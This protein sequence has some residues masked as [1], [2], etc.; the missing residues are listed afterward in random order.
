MDCQPFD[1]ISITKH[2]QV[3]DSSYKSIKEILIKYKA[4]IGKKFYLVHD[5]FAEVFPMKA[6]R[7]IVTAHSHKWAMEAAK[8]FIGYNLRYCLRL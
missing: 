6:S 3:L 2:K 7:L 8:S 5:T 1:G 4:L